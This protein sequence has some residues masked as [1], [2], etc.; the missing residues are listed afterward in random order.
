[1]LLVLS[2]LG[3][4]LT[5]T[6]ISQPTWNQQNRF[7]I[8]E[9]LTYCQM[10]INL[11]LHCSVSLYSIKSMKGIYLPAWLMA[12]IKKIKHSLIGN[13][14][15]FFSMEPYWVDLSLRLSFERMMVFRCEGHGVPNVHGSWGWFGSLRFHPATGSLG[16]VLKDHPDWRLAGRCFA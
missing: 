12:P 4:T 13:N 7:D 6:N 1:M 8:A 16:L 11:C 3:K 9:K 15:P 5:L 10:M 14:I 2:L